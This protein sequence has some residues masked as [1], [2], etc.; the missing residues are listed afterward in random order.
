LLTVFSIGMFAVHPFVGVTGIVL[1]VTGA[2]AAYQDEP[3]IHKK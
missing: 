2:N 1:T 3:T